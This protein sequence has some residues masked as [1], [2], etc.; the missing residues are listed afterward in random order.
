MNMKVLLIGPYGIGNTILALPAMKVL[1]ERFLGARIDLL[2]LLPSVYEMV[3]FLPDFRNV[4]DR[5]FLLPRNPKDAV[6]TLKE[7]FRTRYDWSIVLFPS[8]KLH[9]NLLSYLIHAKE[10]IGS[11]Y[12]DINFRRGHFLNTVNVPVVVGIHDVYQ[13]IRL[14]SP[15]GIDVGKVEVGRL[16]SE[17]SGEKGKVVGIHPGSKARD[18]YR[19]WSSDKFR[20]LVRWMLEEL[21]EY[22]VRL[23]FGPDEMELTGCF[24]DL[25]SDGRIRLKANRPLREVFREINDCEIFISNDSGLMHVANFLGCYTIS[26]WGPSDFRRTGPFNEPKKVIYRDVPCRPCSHTY[27]VRSHSFRCKRVECL[28]KV[29]V[30]DVMKAVRTA[31]SELCTYYT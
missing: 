9:Y 6:G 21:P 5:S 29:E 12:P 24:K 31:R 20:S 13:N 17:W 8:A 10:R 18:S 4:L 14:L 2:C 15:L 16:I 30:E 3:N 25:A 27:Y 19:R 28:E 11:K 22:E 7:L 26:I 23:F 1:R